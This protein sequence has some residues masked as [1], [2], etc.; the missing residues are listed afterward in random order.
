MVSNDVYYFIGRAILKKILLGAV[1]S[2]RVYATQHLRVLVRAAVAEKCSASL[3]QW[4]IP[5]LV[6][7]LKDKCRAVVMAAADI[8][9]EATDDPVVISLFPTIVC[10]GQQLF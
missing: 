5:L 7:Q 4:L 1:E 3:A 6:N 10:N 8:L 2:G 9:A